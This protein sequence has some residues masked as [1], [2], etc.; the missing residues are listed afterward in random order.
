M[1]DHG[2]WRGL[3]AAIIWQAIKDLRRAPADHDPERRA[4]LRFLNSPWGRFLLDLL[5]LGHLTPGDFD[6]AA[7]A[8]L[9]NRIGPA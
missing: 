4:V 8:H 3:A 9:T 6:R 2:A 7:Q 5:D 1:N